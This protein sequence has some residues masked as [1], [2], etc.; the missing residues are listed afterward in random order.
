MTEQYPCPKCGE[1]LIKS[2]NR[3]SPNGYMIPTNFYDGVISKRGE[4]HICP[5]DIRMPSKKPVVQ[6]VNEKSHDLHEFMRN[7]VKL[8]D[9]GWYHLFKDEKYAGRILYAPNDWKSWN[10]EQ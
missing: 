2:E 9:D 10:P 6:Y 7:H 5:K 4:N 1:S 8:G 3:V